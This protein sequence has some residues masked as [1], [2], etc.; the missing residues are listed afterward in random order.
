MAKSLVPGN[1]SKLLPFSKRVAGQAQPIT[2]QFPYHGFITG[3][4]ATWTEMCSKEG[5]GGRVNSLTLSNMRVFVLKSSTALTL[6]VKSG[7]WRE[8]VTS[9]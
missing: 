1:K 3:S 6:I 2:D 9:L 5:V 7:N 8:S 4:T